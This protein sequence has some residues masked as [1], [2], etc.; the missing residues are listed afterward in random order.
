[1]AEI[2]A[3]VVV[4]PD[5]H[6]SGTVPTA[7]PPGEHEIIITVPP[8]PIRR[9]PSEVFDVDALPARDLGPWPDSLSLRREDIYD[10]VG[11]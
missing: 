1:M 5:H 6:I 3:R 7:V 10:E 8:A 4:G 11:R 9:H 2:R